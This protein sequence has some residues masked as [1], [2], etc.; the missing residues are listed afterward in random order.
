[1][2]NFM[3]S[4]SSYTIQLDLPNRETELRYNIN[5]EKGDYLTV[6]ELLR[7][8]A[9]RLEQQEDLKQ[10][11]IAHA[12]Q[13]LESIANDNDNKDLPKLEDS[14]SC[15]P[16]NPAN[17]LLEKIFNFIE[18]NYHQS[19]ALS[20]VAVAVGYSPAY[21][22]DLVRRKTGRTVN[23][24]IVERRMKAAQTLLLETD[25]SV[26]DIAFDIGYQHEGHFFRQFRQYHKVTPKV[27]REAQRI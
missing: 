2:E 26:S 9:A 5:L 21:L 12:R 25:R 8:I 10:C 27:W 17:S 20:D 16:N 11:Y 15:F 13:V 24:W 18:A 6:E 3:L 14:Q 4:T 19:I 7:A 23:H 1:M 22:T